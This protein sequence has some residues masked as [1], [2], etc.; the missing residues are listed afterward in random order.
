MIIPIAM[1][2]VLSVAASAWY[3][4]IGGPEQRTHG[5]DDPS[6]RNDVRATS[7][8][9]DRLNAMLEQKDVALVNVHVPYEGEL[10][11]TDEFIPYDRIGQRLDDLPDKDAEIVLY[12]RSGRMSSIAVDALL[13][14]GYLDVVELRGGFEA[15]EDAGYDLIVREPESR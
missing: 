14:A 9:P 5:N 8:S 4:V 6:P 13:E 3:L 15:W 11:E 10:P 1:L 12:C 2:L 7:V